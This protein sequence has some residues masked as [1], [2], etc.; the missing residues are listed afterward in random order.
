M[1]NGSKKEK[2][3]ESINPFLKKCKAGFPGLLPIY[4]GLALAYGCAG[5]HAYDWVATAMLSMYFYLTAHVYIG[6]YSKSLFGEGNNHIDT[7]S[8]ALVIDCIDNCIFFSRFQCKL[9]YSW[10]T[11]VLSCGVFYSY[12]VKVRYIFLN[13]C[14][15]NSTVLKGILLYI[16]KENYGDYI[17]Y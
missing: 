15:K 5:I 13:F 8:H 2:R 3:E 14:V 7:L 12:I 6:I 1:L 10:K 16:I 4:P 17:Y 11:V 9:S